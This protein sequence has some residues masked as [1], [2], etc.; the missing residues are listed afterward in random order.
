MVDRIIGVVKADGFSGNDRRQWP[1]A[2]QMAA[3]G[4]RWGSEPIE[5]IHEPGASRLEHHAWSIM[6][7]HTRINRVRRR[8]N[9]D[10]RDQR[11]QF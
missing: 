1:A 3:G 10:P 6:E 8:G 2:Y 4:K 11:R 5:R 7:H 9:A